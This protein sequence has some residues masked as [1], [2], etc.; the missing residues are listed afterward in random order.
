MSNLPGVFAEL[1]QFPRVRSRYLDAPLLGQ[2]TSYISHL[3]RHGVPRARVKSVASMQIHAINLMNMGGARLIHAAEVQ[4]AA[5]Q[6]SIDSAVRKR[7]APSKAVSHKFL[8]TVTEWL[9]FSN[10][11]TEPAAPKALFEPQVTQYFR[12]ARARGHAEA[13]IYNRRN[14]LK[15]FLGWLSERRNNLED[16]SLDDIDTYLESRRAKG[17][18]QSTFANIR[19]ELRLFFR[20]CESQHWCKAGISRGILKPASIR[21]S[22]DSRG[23]AWKDVRRML[24]VL[25][26]DPVEIRA[27]AVISLCAIC[28]LR[29]SEIARMRLEDLDWQNEIMTVRRVKRGGVQQF[30]IQHEV[31]QAIL[32]YLKS[33]RPRSSCRSLFTTIRTPIRPISPNSIGMI[34][35]KRMTM[36]KIKSHNFGPH[37]LRHSCAT[38]LLNKGFS[39]QEIAEFL[40]HRGLQAVSIYAKYNPRLLRNVASFSLV[41]VR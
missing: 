3:L 24:S 17:Y 23:P 41:G 5:L 7:I 32:S 30:P 37:S 19:G 10:L 33:A 14:L 25:A 29:R 31:G 22:P 21:L 36:L 20:Y 8:R 27:N 13:A 11:I 12:D 39:L 28:A 16:V 18:R 35:R 2:R 26:T 6:W 40:G 34:V 4:Q 15:A 9:A 38:Q 1:F